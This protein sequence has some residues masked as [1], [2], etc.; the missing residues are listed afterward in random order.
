MTIIQE[1]SHPKTKQKQIRF[2]LL[3]PGLKA[4]SLSLKN[5]LVSDF[6]DVPG[7]KRK[8]FKE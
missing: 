7:R 8:Q 1:L 2:K 3:K 5:K 6:T 4:S